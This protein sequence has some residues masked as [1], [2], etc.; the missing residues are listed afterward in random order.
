MKRFLRPMDGAKRKRDSAQ[1]QR[2]ARA[3][4]GKLRSSWLQLA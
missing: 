1:P 3:M 4:D 2:L